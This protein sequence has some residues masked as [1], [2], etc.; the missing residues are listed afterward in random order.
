MQT[1]K[2]C[3]QMGMPI[4]SCHSHTQVTHLFGG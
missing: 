1:E 4:R 3:F 2:F